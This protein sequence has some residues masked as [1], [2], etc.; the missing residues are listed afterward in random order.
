[1]VVPVDTCIRMAGSLCCPSETITTL[2]I[3]YVHAKSLQ[4]RLTL[5]NTMDC[6][7]PGSSERGIL[8]AR[9]LEWIT[10]S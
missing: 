8:Q 7:Q 1:M 4:S 10:M 9:I 5:F 2:L 3:G 6:S